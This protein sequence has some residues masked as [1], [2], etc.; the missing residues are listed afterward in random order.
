MG[1]R[2]GSF[3]DVGLRFLK[4]TPKTAQLSPLQVSN[5]PPLPILDFFLFSILPRIYCWLVGWMVG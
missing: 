5:S 4:F 2:Q 1:D 3:F